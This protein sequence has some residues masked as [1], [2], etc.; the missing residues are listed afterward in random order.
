MRP[1]EVE[2]CSRCF[3]LILPP[4]EP[5]GTC[6]Q[7]RDSPEL[8]EQALQNVRKLDG[9]IQHLREQ[10]RDLE[11][12]HALDLEP[13]QRAK[14]RELLAGYRQSLRRVEEDRAKAVTIRAKLTSRWAAHEAVSRRLEVSEDKLARAE[15]RLARAEGAVAGAG[16]EGAVARTRVGEHGRIS[17]GTK[18]VSRGPRRHTT[19]SG[20]TSSR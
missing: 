14:I 16:A 11:E 15:H 3:S 6:A 1:L 4:K 5:C 9:M 17:H 19:G 10:I 2:R 8:L 7:L 18:P 20:T 12:L 13:E